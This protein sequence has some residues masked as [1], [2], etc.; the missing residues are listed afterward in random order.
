MRG[1]GRRTETYEIVLF[2]LAY[3]ELDLL[4]REA[5]R[6]LSGR[7]ATGK[8]NMPGAD[9]PAGGTDGTMEDVPIL[10]YTRTILLPVQ[11]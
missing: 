8:S 2:A 3:F 11:A 6:V 10:V 7:N 5:V 9:T 4:W 1:Q